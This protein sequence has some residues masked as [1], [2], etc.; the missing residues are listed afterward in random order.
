MLERGV[1]LGQLRVQVAGHLV[2]CDVQHEGLDAPL[3]L[4]EIVARDETCLPVDE[5][6]K[7]FEI[8]CSG[9]SGKVLL[10][11]D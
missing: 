6:E 5:F 1:D 9:Q 4:A 2:G 11:W 3:V 7:G 10:Y 8:M